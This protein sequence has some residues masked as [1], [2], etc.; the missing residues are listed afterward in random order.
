MHKF[1]LLRDKETLYFWY[2]DPENYYQSMIYG[3]VLHSKG[4]YT[5]RFATRLLE[6]GNIKNDSVFDNEEKCLKFGVES[7]R[8]CLESYIS[9]INYDRDSYKK[10]LI[11]E[12]KESVSSEKKKR[13][14]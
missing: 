1:N 4:K 5:C 3:Y 7:L 8:K 12:K 14:D 13:K 11:V 10:T 6:Q 2:G 9:G